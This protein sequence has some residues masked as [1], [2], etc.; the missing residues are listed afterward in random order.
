MTHC[1]P[2]PDKDV[3]HLINMLATGLQLGTPCINTFSGEAM[4]GKMEVSFEQQ[5]H[6]VHCVKDHDLELVVQE[7]IVRSLKGAVADMAWYM[8]P[9]ASV[10][11]ILPKFPIIFGIVASFNVLMQNLY[12]VTQG[13]H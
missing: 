8:G 11:H 10:A 6:K 9:T 4:P 13:N 5:Y 2:Q 12:K 1:P 7:S 3:V